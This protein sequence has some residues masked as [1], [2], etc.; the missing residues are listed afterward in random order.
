MA[1]VKSNVISVEDYQ[2]A[3]KLIEKM[4]PKLEEASITIRQWQEA[5][6]S[7]PDLT[8][9]GPVVAVEKTESGWRVTVDP[10]AESSRQDQAAVNEAQ[11]VLQ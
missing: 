10:I 11:P 2:E 5:V 3:R 9:K 6:K 8:G 7:R 1:K 4:R